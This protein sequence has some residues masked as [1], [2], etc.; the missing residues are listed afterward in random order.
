VIFIFQFRSQNLALKEAAYQKALDDYT[1]TISLLVT[2]P[3]LTKLV[4][5]LR[6]FDKGEESKWAELS[7]EKKAFF[8]YF[9]LNYSLFERVY[10]PYA[11]KWIDEDTW[12]QWHGWLKSMARH[13]MFQEV[14]R[15]SQGT[16]DR[17]FQNLVQEA[18]PKG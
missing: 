11:R 5:E 10:L 3:D 16:F 2:R 15:A 4:D 6:E 14:H 9:L 8:G 1:D 17:A 7:P 18:I 12:S 13:P